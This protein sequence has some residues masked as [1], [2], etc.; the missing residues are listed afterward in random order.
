[1]DQNSTQEYLLAFL[2]WLDA[3]RA[4][5]PE[6]YRRRLERVLARYGVDSLGDRGGL[7]RATFW[8]FR[9]FSRVP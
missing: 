1:M 3:D 8:M 2:Q 9:S 5:L 6:R 7:E 4:G